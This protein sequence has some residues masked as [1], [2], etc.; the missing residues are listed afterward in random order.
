MPTPAIEVRT[1]TAADIDAVSIVLGSAFMKD[2]I[3]GWI[4]PDDADRER[5]H[6]AFFRPF[7]EIA[8]ADGE[9]H[10]A[11]DFAGVALWLP[12]DGHGVAD[13]AG[14]LN[15]IMESAIGLEHAK[16][17]AVLDELMTINHPSDPHHYLPFIAV[18]PDHQGTGVGST[19]LTHQLRQLDASGSAAYLEASCLRNAAL[20]ARLGFKHMAATIDLPNGPSLYPMWRAPGG[21]A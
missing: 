4:F 12:V 9:V 19:L 3:S 16:R 8:V 1:A 14:D 21:V 2:P 18:H 7:A 17:F 10:I 15:A 13:E 5:L 20:Y 6:P 11:G